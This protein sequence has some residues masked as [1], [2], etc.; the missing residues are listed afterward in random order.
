MKR[1]L[2]FN[3]FET[4]KVKVFKYDIVKIEPIE[5]LDKYKDH[6]R[7]RVFYHKGTKCVSCERVGTQ[8]V[9]GRDNQGNIHKDVCTD[10]LYPLTID[11]IHPKSKGG[12][13]TLKN[14]QPMCSEC[15]KE[16]ADVVEGG[17]EYHKGMD[18]PNENKNKYK[19]RRKKEAELRKYIREN[20][21]SENIEIGDVVYKKR[22]GVELGEV[23]EILPNPHHPHKNLSARVKEQN[24]ESLYTLNS[25]FKKL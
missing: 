16:K 25:L 20:P 21:S 14:L 22:D 1:I 19:S 12:K 13:N 7:L 10:D 4:K 3:E 17:G 18:K 24:P 9:H 2:E 5:E 15:N 23:I 11:H 8:I 6:R